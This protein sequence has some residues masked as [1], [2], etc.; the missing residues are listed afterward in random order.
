[1]ID[2]QPFIYSRTKE[3][4]YQFLR[5]PSEN[6]WPANYHVESCFSG[7]REAGIT[8]DNNAWFFFCDDSIKVC[9]LMQNV[10]VTDR[11]GMQICDHINRSI[12]SMDGFCCNYN[13]RHEFFVLIPSLIY[14]VQNSGTSLYTNIIHEKSNINFL[15]DSF[16]VD[17]YTTR[18]NVFSGCQKLCQFIYSS[19]KPTSFLFGR[20]IY[21]LKENQ[22]FMAQYHFSEN[23]FIDLVF[24]NSTSD[25][26]KKTFGILPQKKMIQGKKKTIHL[27]VILHLEKEGYRW[28]VKG[29]DVCYQTDL[30]QTMS[31]KNLQN[32]IS[33]IDNYLS[34][35]LRM[36]KI[37]SYEFEQEEYV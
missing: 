16:I 33:E 5:R 6:I 12:F 26:A 4:D 18:T 22:S 23:N 25:S 14:S 15:N 24:G 13:D 1:M 30:R 19:S 8:N 32:E 28:Q 29:D 17:P 27:K 7:F 9:M 2:I 10:K 3:K 31:Y 20:N 34:K 37:G 35:Q 11:N 21:A 36:R